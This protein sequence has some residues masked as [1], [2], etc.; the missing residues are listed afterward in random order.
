MRLDVGGI[1]KGFAADEALAVLR[2]R[3]IHRALV[4]AAGDIALGE[5]PPNQAGWIVSVASI[6]VPE[7]PP[8]IR[9]ALRNCGVSTSGDLFQFVEIE[10]VRYSHIVDPRTGLG[11][12]NQSLVTVIAADAITADSVATAISV[13]GPAPGIAYAQSDPTISCD[14]IWRQSGR[15]LR[16]STANFDRLSKAVP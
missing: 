11:L 5:A 14:V 6:E 12:T 1:A 16:R 10:G 3:G 15:F 2:A 9:L 7:A 4:A 8:S 13:L